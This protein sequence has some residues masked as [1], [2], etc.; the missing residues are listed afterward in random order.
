MPNYADFNANVA[1]GWLS[2]FPPSLLPF[3]LPRGQTMD[4]VVPVSLSS[5]SANSQCFRTHGS[6]F[7]Y[8]AVSALTRFQ[9]SYLLSARMRDSTSVHLCQRIQHIR[10]SY[11]EVYGK[12]E[13][14]LGF[15]V[16]FTVRIH[17]ETLGKVFDRKNFNFKVMR[18]WKSIKHC[19]A[20]TK[21]LK[22]SKSLFI[23]HK[24]YQDLQ[25]LKKLSSDTFRIRIR[26]SK[27][28]CPDPDREKKWPVPIGNNSSFQL[29]L[30]FVQNQSLKIR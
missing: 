2:P 24:V 13:R 4:E 7:D 22:V 12:W 15:D 14:S 26:V 8:C 27:M 30:C 18:I 6:L 23:F 3:R 25:V 16:N 10:T 9:S 21:L 17:T 11:L 20:K 19:H 28:L 1:C 5:Y 29:Q